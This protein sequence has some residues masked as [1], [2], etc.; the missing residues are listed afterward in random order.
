MSRK[1]F[2]PNL[3]AGNQVTQAA[4]KPGAGEDGKVLAWNNGLKK[5]DVVVG[6]GGAGAAY[7]GYYNLASGNFP[8]LGVGVLAGQ[9]W[10]AD[11]AGAAGVLQ[12]VGVPPGA[13]IEAGINA[14]GNLPAN[15]V[16]NQ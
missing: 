5:Y 12:G 4:R 10:I 16:V 1:S 9:Y 14:P 11:P 2:N 7:Q 13:R 3:I 15:W 8:L 6:G